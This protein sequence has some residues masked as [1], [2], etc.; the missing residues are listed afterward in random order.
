[1]ATPYLALVNELDV[2]Q[3]LL[4]D[5]DRN[6]HFNEL[7]PFNDGKGDTPGGD[8]ADND[9]NLTQQPPWQES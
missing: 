5:P 2:I 3:E 9:A 4:R 6:F 8:S 1:M 7:V